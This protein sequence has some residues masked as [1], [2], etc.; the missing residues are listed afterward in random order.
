MSAEF[1]AGV[2]FVPLAAVADAD[3]GAPALAQALS[4]KESSNQS[5]TQSLE[6]YLSGLHETF[7]LFLDNFERWLRGEKLRNVHR[8]S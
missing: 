4:L 6:E 8:P 7:L 1:P 2:C 5:P 3:S